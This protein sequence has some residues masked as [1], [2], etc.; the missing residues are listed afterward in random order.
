M[1]LLIR[2]LATSKSY[3]VCVNATVNT[4]YRRKKVAQV[5]SSGAHSSAK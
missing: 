3:M 2:L 4:M 1:V 5:C